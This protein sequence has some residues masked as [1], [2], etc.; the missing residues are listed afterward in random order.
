VTPDELRESLGRGELRT[1]YLVVGGE[2]LLRDEA[3]AALRVAVLGDAPA[4]FDLEALDGER[5]SASALLD[6]LRTLP[7]LAPRRLVILRE[8]EA[9]GSARG[10][11]EALAGIVGE[12]DPQAQSVLV[13]VVEKADG[14]ARWVKAFDAPAL[15]RCDAPRSQRE[16]VGF[17]HQE[18]R[19]QG[20]S[21]DAGAAELLAERVGPQL[22][23]LRREIEKAALLATA[24][25]RVGRAAVAAGTPT[26]ADEP[27]WDL[28]DAI[29]EGRTAD[30]LRVLTHLLG[31]GSAP[32]LVLGSIA[33]HFRRL[34][35]LRSGG[36]VQAPPFVLRKL[37]RQARRYGP[38]RLAACLRAI[39]ETD[40]ALKGAGHLRPEL[41]LER[42][43]LGLS[44]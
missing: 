32:P 42:L 22:M 17:V 2:A 5:L 36:S 1:A 15:V 25:G 20:V 30:A 11:G 29:G 27:V 34:L 3:L 16:V 9:R 6:A 33:S 40:L 24:E 37:D 19:R 23:L 13:V 28:T 31:G 43:V 21:I 14:R 8:P 12:P 44:G 18:G 35:R 26:L 10:L 39:H 4:D 38:R 41:A 7:V